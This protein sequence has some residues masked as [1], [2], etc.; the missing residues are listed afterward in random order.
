MLPVPIALAMPYTSP[1]L[2]THA[3]VILFSSFP[4]FLQYCRKK[5]EA[6]PCGEASVVRG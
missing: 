6:S 3:K 5:K 4:L 2:V 1:L